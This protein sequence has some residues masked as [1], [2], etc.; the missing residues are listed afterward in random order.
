[1]KLRHLRSTLL[2]AL[3]LLVFLGCT[4]PAMAGS[5]LPTE[6]TYTL[7]GVFCYGGGF[8]GYVVVDFYATNVGEV[9]SIRT[10][11]ITVSPPTGSGLE[12]VEFTPQTPGSSAT[13]TGD[14]LF[15]VLAYDPFQLEWSVDALDPLSSSP[16]SITGGF[17]LDNQ[18][19]QTCVCGGTMTPTP[20]PATWALMT[21]G[22][23]VLL[24]LAWRRRRVA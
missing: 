9:K 14:P 3:G 16:V 18:G 13:I 11:D 20:E 7:D 12:P 2:Y 19:E 17:Y 6:V 1:M 22:G 10:W 5:L 15:D 8:N 21:G 24:G 23:L 4:V